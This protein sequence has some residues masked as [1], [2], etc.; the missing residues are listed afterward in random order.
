MFVNGPS[1]L[2]VG[3]CPGALRPMESGDGLIVRIR[4]RL[5]RLSLVQLETLAQAAQRSGDGNLYLSN[6]ANV[7]IR[8]VTAAG[9][10]ALLDGLAAVSLIDSDARIEAVRNIMVA[11]AVELSTHAGL[12]AGLAARLENVLAKTEAL[13]R[14]PGKFGIA[15][16][17]GTEIDSAAMSDVTFLVQGDAVAMVPEGA[18]DQAFLFGTTIAAAE[19]FKALGMAFLRLRRAQPAIRR[20]RD[21]IALLGME[22]VSR[23]AGLPYVAHGLPVAEAPAPLGDLGEAFGIGFTFGEIGQAALLDITTLMRR[24]CI[25]EAAISSR[26]AL[27]FPAKEQEKAALRDLAKRIGGITDPMNI[28]L[29]LHGCP[30]SPACHRATVEARQDAEAVLQALAGAGFM[31]TI[32]ISGCEKRCAYPHDAGI[33]A[34]GADGR[35]TVTGS[36]SKTLNGVA[37]ADLPSVI[38]ELARAA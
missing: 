19:G 8:G 3:W 12:A 17:A 27:V 5:S 25:A 26:R 18:A 6:R 16:Q 23:D 13:Y 32:H 24:E 36:G 22:A 35:Y 15:V 9:H 30:G 28:G 21:A 34:I 38:A 29:R 20:M 7:Q 10:A 31:G 33:C 2:I 14:L 37:G 1:N 4:P 11:P